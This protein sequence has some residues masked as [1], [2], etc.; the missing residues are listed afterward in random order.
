MRLELRT[1]I[2]DLLSP[3]HCASHFGQGQAIGKVQSCSLTVE[4]SIVLNNMTVK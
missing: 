3:R 2:Y 4:T 1:A